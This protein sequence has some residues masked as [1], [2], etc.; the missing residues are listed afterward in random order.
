V[1][2]EDGDDTIVNAASYEDVVSGDVAYNGNEYLFGGA[3]NDLIRATHGNDSGAGYV[4]GIQYLYGGDGQD[5]IYGG[6]AVDG[7][8]TMAGGDGDDWLVGG[9][10]GDGDTQYIYGDSADHSDDWNG[11]DYYEEWSVNNPWYM[12]TD[13]G[14]D[15]IYGGD[16]TQ[17]Q[18]LIGGY[19]D[20]KIFS[21]NDNQETYVYIYGD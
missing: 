17:D 11:T 12:M 7:K 6:D 19:G 18:Y 4:Y 14:N 2:G 9:D 20:D 15:V 8:Q 13:T 5:K 16:Y 3:G 10:G 1:Y 21:G